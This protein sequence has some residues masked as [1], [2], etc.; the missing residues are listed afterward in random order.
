MAGGMDRVWYG[1]KRSFH[2]T[3]R[4]ARRDFKELGLTAARMDILHALFRV[5]AW[6]RPIWQSA[7][8][9]IIGY[10]ARSTMTVMLRALEGLLWIRRKRSEDDRRQLEVELTELGRSELK[11]AYRR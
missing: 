10:T 2:S 5:R 1:L 9:R 8:R 7:L 3:L 6:K 11:R 4:V